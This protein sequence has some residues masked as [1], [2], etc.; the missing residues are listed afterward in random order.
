MGLQD[1]EREEQM[2]VLPTTIGEEVLPNLERLPK[3]ELSL[4]ADKNPAIAKEQIHGVD[5]FKIAV[6]ERIHHFERA[7]NKLWRTRLH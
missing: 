1:G 5:L 2:K 4:E 7:L 3:R 6:E